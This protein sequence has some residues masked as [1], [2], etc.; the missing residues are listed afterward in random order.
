MPKGIYER[1]PRTPKQYPAL[2]VRQV[3]ALYEANHT[4]NEV[5]SILGTTQKVI[6][7]LM[8]HHDIPRRL[9]VKRNQHGPNNDSWRGD[10]ATYA[11]MHKRVESLRGCPSVCE[12]CDTTTASRFE[13]ANI[14]GRYNDTADYVRL[15]VSCHRQLD[16]RRRKAT[17]AKT[18]RWHRRA[19][20]ERSPNARN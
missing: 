8:Q 7:R 5:A 13:W 16:A 14:S 10:D 4:Q 12:Q 2:L 20:K 1:K 17:G 15:C 6:W 9:T 19:R 3:T 18:E 11:A